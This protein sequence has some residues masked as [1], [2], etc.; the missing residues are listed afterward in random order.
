MRW[1]K[2]IA[3]AGG[4]MMWPA[5]ACAQQS[6]MPVVGFLHAGTLD[7]YANQ[8]VA[9][10]QGLA[11]AGFV[12]G[13]NVAIEYRWAAG[14]YDRLSAL[15]AEL[16]ARP[17][18]V[19]YTS[20]GPLHDFK[21]TSG[22][23]PV[24]FTTGSDPIEA[25]LVSSLS[26]PDGNVTGVSFFSRALGAKRL[27]LIREL[28]PNAAVIAVLQ[29]TR[30]PMR[31]PELSELQA[32]ASQL[33]QQLRVVSAGTIEEIDRAFVE[34]DRQR[35]DALIVYGDLLFTS[36]RELIIALA[37]RYAIPAFYGIAD[38]PRS[39]GLMSYGASIVEAYRQAGLYAGRILKGEKPADLPVLLPS[40]YELVINLKTA[41]T[42]GLKVPEP[43]LLFRVDEVIE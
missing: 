20:S 14:Q 28:L 2:F 17:V 27:E 40:K 16:L 6:A 7:G 26:R 33:G 32:A 5:M 10:R 15:A 43:F 35:P 38:F 29:N 8:V 12:A 36:Q 11:Q 9:F 23:T 24:V 41:K 22:S 19:L 4:A 18:A 25:R 34:L 1:R 31:G 21:T 39:G 3:L 42:L 37:A 30:N 13:Q